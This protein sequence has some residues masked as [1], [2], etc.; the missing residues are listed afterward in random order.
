MNCGGSCLQIQDK[1]V[2]LLRSVLICD[3]EPIIRMSLKNKLKELGFDEIMECSDGE[4]AV[5]TALARVPDF[6][7]LDISM[8][9]KDGITAAREIRKRLKIPIIFLTAAYDPDTVKRAREAGIAAFLTKPLREQDLWPTIELAF[10]H[11]EEVEHLK[12]EVEDLKETIESRKVIEKAKGILMQK[13]GLSE[14]EAFR[15][16]QKLAMDKRKSMRQVAEAILLTE[17]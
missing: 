6:A 7:I 12:E 2:N 10:A 8:P 13:H 5:T 3:D 11:A 14:P 9:K 17:S 1:V 16:M 15:R 4:C